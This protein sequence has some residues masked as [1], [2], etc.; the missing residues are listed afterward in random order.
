MDLLPL[1]IQF[2]LLHKVAVRVRRY[3]FHICILLLPLGIEAA[4]II[5]LRSLKVS[6]VPIVTSV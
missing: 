5:K 4:L 1:N 6:V 3:D 2:D